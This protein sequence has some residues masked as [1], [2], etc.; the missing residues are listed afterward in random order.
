METIE[1]WSTF[2]TRVLAPN[3]GFMTLD[4]TNSLII[5]HPDAPKAVL[6]DPGPLDE[7]HLQRLLEIAEYELILLTHNHIDHSESAA[8]MHRRTGAPV[9][10]FDP[11][12]TFGGETLKDGEVIE[13][14]GCR[15]EVLETP[16][17]S[18]DSVCFVLPDDAPVGG[19]EPGVIL[20]GDTILGRGT[21]VVGTTGTLAQYL[22]SMR[23]LEAL[24]SLFV[25]PAHGGTL[26]SLSAIS[27]ELLAHRTDR[28]DQTRQA[29]AALG[30]AASLEQGTIEAVTDAVYPDVDSS[31]RFA[32][33]MTTRSNLEYVLTFG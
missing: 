6:V 25:A 29:L 18:L 24:G 26:P 11:V 3:P 4:G 15:I 9:R 5:K 31:I 33:Q 1:K 13:A 22:D 12:F 23:R 2:V 19:G 27:Q 17:H 32:A 14:G 28:I 30:L 16:G 8:E 10:A 20:S 21:T 7:G